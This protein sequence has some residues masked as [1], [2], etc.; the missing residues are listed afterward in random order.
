MIDT[1]KK[2]TVLHCARCGEDHIEAI[3][4]HEFKRPVVDNDGTI[5]AYWGT[6]PMTGD[7]ILGRKISS[8]DDLAP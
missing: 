4:Y 1:A 2:Q 5:W 3:V 6:C 8:E 7:P